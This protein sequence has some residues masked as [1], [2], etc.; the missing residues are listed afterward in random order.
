MILSFG[1][2]SLTAVGNAA[3]P[4][5]TIPA[6]ATLALISSGVIVSGL[7]GGRKL[8]AFQLLHLF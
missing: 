7:R 3:P 1:G 2:E 4:C 5:P 8:F 6:S